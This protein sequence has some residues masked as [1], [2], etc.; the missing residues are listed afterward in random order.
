MSNAGLPSAVLILDT[1]TTGVDPAV[2]KVIEVAAILYDLNLA[3]PTRS[4]ASLIYQPKNP[5]EHVNHIPEAALLAAPHESAVW[6]HVEALASRADVALAHNA[7]FDASFVPKLH[8]SLPWVDSMFLDWP[9]ASTSRKLI[10]IACAHGV[11]IC[12]AHRALADCDLIAR[13]LT[14]VAEKGIK[15]PEFIAR[16]MRPRRTIT[17]L[18]PYEKKDL[19]KQH[20]FRWNAERKLWM[21][22]VFEDDKT[23]YPFK[24][25]AGKKP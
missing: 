6:I 4:F 13:L 3:M 7:S 23:V 19:A 10:D 5:A 1:E 22:E 11:G 24:T 17:A 9:Q 20:G 21:K 2:D 8:M 14:C 16:A 12:Q 15:L 25:V 18:V